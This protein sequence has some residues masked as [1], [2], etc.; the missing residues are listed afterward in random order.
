MCSTIRPLLGAHCFGF[1]QVAH[2]CKTPTNS[3][4]QTFILGHLLTSSLR[5]EGA[6]CPP[7]SAPF[8][9]PLFQFR[10]SKAFL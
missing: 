7:L 10:A 2:F 6:K 4:H 3:L 1:L 5:F 8:R 9:G